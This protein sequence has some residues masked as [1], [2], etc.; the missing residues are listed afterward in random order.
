MANIEVILTEKIEGLG[1][2]ADVVSVRGGYARNFLL[3]RG[4]AYEATRANKRHTEQLKTKRAARES[5]ELAEAGALAAA[6]MKKPVKLELA[7]GQGGKAFGAITAKDIAEAIETQL[8]RKIDRQVIALDKPVKTTGEHEIDVR[9]H[10]E[11]AA[12]LRLIVKATTETT[13]SKEDAPAAD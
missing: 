7:T 12:T 1:A 2:E 11:V 13:E 6:L 8:G 10:P 5:A 9:I 3:P 4:L